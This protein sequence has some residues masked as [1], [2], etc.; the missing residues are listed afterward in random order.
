M[1]AN[2]QNVVNG[3]IPAWNYEQGG[4][5]KAAASESLCWD[6][7]Y[8]NSGCRKG[9]CYNTA[10]KEHCPLHTDRI[11]FSAGLSKASLRV[12]SP[13]V[14]GC[15]YAAIPSITTSD[16]TPVTASFSMIY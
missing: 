15:S 14:F 13:K 12:K 10:R 1:K 2:L 16:H 6:R 9:L 4:K 8:S 5:C 3:N 11:L 7:D